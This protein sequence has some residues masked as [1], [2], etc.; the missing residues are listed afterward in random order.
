ML[1]TLE[2]RD[3]I[4]SNYQMRRVLFPLHHFPVCNTRIC[5]LLTQ[6]LRQEQNLHM[7]THSDATQD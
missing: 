5:S 4:Q 2:H 6:L 7:N 1:P 3:L